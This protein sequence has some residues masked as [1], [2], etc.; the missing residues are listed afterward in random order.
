MFHSWDTY[1]DRACHLV[2]LGTRERKV[3][4]VL[5]PDLFKVTLLYEHFLLECSLIF[6]LLVESR[7]LQPTPKR[8]HI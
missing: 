5:L 2:L 3:S 8:Y 7:D 1:I 6:R 4:Y